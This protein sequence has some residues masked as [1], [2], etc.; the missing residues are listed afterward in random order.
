MIKFLLSTCLFFS[1]ATYCAAQESSNYQLL[2]NGKAVDIDLGKPVDFKTAK[3]EQ[4]KI[5]LKQ[6]DVLFYKDDVVSLNYPKEFSVSKSVPDNNIEQLAIM[7]AHGSGV[8]IQKYNGLNPSILVDMMLQ[9]VIKESINYGYTQKDQSFEKKLVSGQ[10]LKGKMA[11]LHYKGDEQTYVVAAYGAKDEGILVLTM[12]NST[13]VE[14]D[15]KLLD[16]V[17]NTLSYKSL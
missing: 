9:E 14:Q 12:I 5:E 16:M 6:K 3:G 10:V 1:F 8:L 2:I 13:Y 11:T 15:Q 7:T 4:L 17:L